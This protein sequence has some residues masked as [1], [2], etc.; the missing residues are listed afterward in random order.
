MGST[1]LNCGYCHFLISPCAR[2]GRRKIQLSVSDSGM[3]V[4]VSNRLITIN[5]MISHRDIRKLTVWSRLDRQLSLTDSSDVLR[6]RVTD[7][8]QLCLPT[9]RVLNRR[10]RISLLGA[11]VDL[12]RERRSEPFP[13]VFIAACREPVMCCA[14][15][16]CTSRE[17]CLVSSC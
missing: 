3:T 10:H 6:S 17:L 16:W 12:L 4:G 9:L 1:G 7:R 11:L 8:L 14:V 5:F 2:S 13:F 15:P